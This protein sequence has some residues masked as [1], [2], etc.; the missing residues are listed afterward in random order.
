MTIIIFTDRDCEYDEESEA[1]CE[2]RMD[3]I[4]N[5]YCL[6]TTYVTTPPFTAENG[7]RASASERDQDANGTT[8]GPVIALGVLFCISVL[9]LA[10]VTIGWVCSCRYVMTKRDAKRST[11]ELKG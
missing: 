5:G 9:L 11:V 6:S 8:L 1:A 3:D 4:L 10:T 7:G 2:D